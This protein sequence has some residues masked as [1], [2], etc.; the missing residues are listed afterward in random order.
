MDWH[1]RIAAAQLANSK[2][3]YNETDAKIANLIAL[4]DEILADQSIDGIFALSSLA[5]SLDEHDKSKA[6]ELQLLAVCRVRERY[7]KLLLPT[8]VQVGCFYSKHEELDNAA[9]YF[10]EAFEI[11]KAHVHSQKASEKMN[12]N[13]FLKWL[14]RIFRMS[15]AASL[16]SELTELIDSYLRECRGFYIKSE[17]SDAV[18]EIEEILENA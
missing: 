13:A 10:D 12:D 3:D 16:R 9:P 15:E 11:A 4:K 18:K 17:N 1:E 2:L 6:E 5:S 14:L 8:L 7:P